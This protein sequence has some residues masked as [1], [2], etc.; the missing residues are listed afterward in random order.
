MSGSSVD[1]GG[2]QLL[3]CFFVGY[4]EEGAEQ[5]KSQD[6]AFFPRRPMPTASELSQN[7]IKEAR[8]HFDKHDESGAGTLSR[9]KLAS[10]LVEATKIALV[11]VRR[12]MRS[13]LPDKPDEAVDLQKY[14]DCVAVLKAINDNKAEREAVNIKLLSI[15][16]LLFVAFACFTKIVFFVCV[17]FLA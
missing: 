15:L 8:A 1:S 3:E 11:N 7:E 12:V 2:R 10:A 5:A 13:L 16:I 6:L 14:L 17:R 4:L 9:A